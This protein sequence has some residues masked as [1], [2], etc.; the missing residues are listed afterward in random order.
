MR[1]GVTFE[2]N[3]FNDI[4]EPYWLIHLLFIPSLIYVLTT[5]EKLFIEKNYSKS[6]ESEV[7]E[8]FY[9]QAM[10]ELE[11]N[12]RDMGF[13][14][15][16]YADSADEESAKKLYIK[17]RAQALNDMASTAQELSENQARKERRK[18]FF[19]GLLFWVIVVGMV[20]IGWLQ[21]SLNS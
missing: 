21:N 17:Y 16:A 18:D 5:K 12:K 6:S 13:W 14:S 11:N 15:K 9:S 1:G 19:I 2:I 8:M 20:V 7:D 3:F 4:I 10:E